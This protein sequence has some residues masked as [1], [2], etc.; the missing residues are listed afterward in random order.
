VAEGANTSLAGAEL[1]RRMGIE[2]PITAQVCAV[3]FRDK[4]PREAIA[5]LMG[6]ELKAEQ[7]R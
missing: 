5:E 2:L 7:W 1:S 3:L 4:P 6:R